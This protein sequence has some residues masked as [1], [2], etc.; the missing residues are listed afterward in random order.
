MKGTIDARLPDARHAILSDP[1]ERAEHNTIVDLLRNDLSRIAAGVKVNRFRY[2]EELQTH[3]GPILQVS[4]EIEASC[5]KIT[6][7]AWHP[8]LQTASC[9]LRF[10]STQVGYAC[11]DPQSRE[12]TPRLLHRCG[13]LLRWQQARHLRAD[14]VYRAAGHASLLPQ[15]RGH[16]GAKRLSQRIHEAL[17][18]VYLPF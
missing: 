17:Q 10:R 12:G 14:K 7:A 13:R 6:E 5:R 8:L 18:K 4:S 9:R 1:K 2:V 15:R 11:S 16:H 3:K